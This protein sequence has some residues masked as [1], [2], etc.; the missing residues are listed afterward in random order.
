MTQTNI[1][2]CWGQLIVEEFVRLG[3]DYFCIAPGSRSSPLSVPAGQNTKVTTFVHFD[4]RGLAFHAL[5]YASVHKK[6]VV[7]ICTSG[8]AVANFFPAIVEASKKKVPL[9]VLS[10]DRP[11]ELRQTGAVQTI[12]QVG[13]FGKYVKHFTDLPCPDLN[14]KPEFVLTTVDQAWYQA[15]RNP[16]GVAHIN[17]MFR[18]PLVPVKTKDD[19]ASYSKSL[20]SWLKSNKPYTQYTSSDTSGLKDV[21][22]IAEVIDGIKKGVI[23]VGKIAQ[24]E[25]KQVL[26]LS[27]KLGWPIFADL[28]SGI[29][30]GC[31]HKNVIHY[32]DQ[33]LL[34]SREQSRLF[35]T[36]DG[37]L[38]LGGRMTSKRYYELIEKLNPKAYIMVLNHS[39]RNDPSHQVTL[40]VESSVGNF[41]KTMTPLVKLRAGNADLRS[42]QN[43][44]KKVD[45]TIEKFLKSDGRLSEIAAARL[46][47]GLIPQGTGL[48]VSNSMPIR[49][50]EFYGDFKGQDV[51]IGGN[52]GASGIDGIL[53]SASGFAQGLNKPVTLMVGDLAALHDL[54]SLAMLRDLS[55]P[56]IIVVL[57][58]G[59]GGIFSFLPIAQHTDVFEKYYG[60]PHSYT[61]ANAAA[62][63]ELNYAQPMDT[64]HFSKAYTKALK[65][66]TSTIIEVIT[67][68]EENLKT[69]K[70]L[71]EQIVGI[72]GAK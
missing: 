70:M 52:R 66:S 21:K 33:I 54:N 64:D 32:F 58:N 2:H 34:Q 16:S 14:I 7:L 9:I 35:P 59:G 60:T 6:P 20:S 46:V 41:C 48:F 26:A 44:N 11:P 45:Q 31:S 42:L 18:D 17:C 3:C 19:L 50:M 61:M 57:N 4:E 72:R 69:H 62:M 55:V 5:G 47:S 36:F 71:Q 13:I 63:F 53:A 49:D 39:L 29:R 30:L 10:A 12:D 1:N 38:H 15:T 37:V 25:Q 24:T 43:L 40:R 56:V 51:V 27:E 23:F 28:V 65:S 22:Q 68:R 8:T 67:G